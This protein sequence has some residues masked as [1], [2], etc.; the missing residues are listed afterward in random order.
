ME[1]VAIDFLFGVVGIALLLLLDE[2]LCDL[3]N[4][5]LPPLEIIV[6]LISTSV[7]MPIS[8]ALAMV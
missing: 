4:V 2:D 1:I 7:D 5:P 6:P 3:R 8:S